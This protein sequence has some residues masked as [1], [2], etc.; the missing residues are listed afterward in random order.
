MGQPP[1]CTSQRSLCAQ[2]RPTGGEAP[3]GCSRWRDFHHWILLVRLDEF[4]EYKLLVTYACRRALWR[5]D[6][7]HI[8]TNFR[9]LPFLFGSFLFF[10]STNINADPLQQ[11]CSSRHSTISSIR[12][13]LWLQRPWQPTLWFEPCSALAF[14]YSL[15]RHSRR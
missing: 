15:A 4:P 13:S 6:N 1:L 2:T 10:C 9:S 14:H 12:T 3:D 7:I 5:F 8:C 11:H